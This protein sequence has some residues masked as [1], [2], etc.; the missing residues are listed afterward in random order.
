MLLQKTGLRNR[1][2]IAIHAHS[3]GL[4]GDDNDGLEQEE[5]QNCAATE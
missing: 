5:F 2:E 1:T 4:L 3:N